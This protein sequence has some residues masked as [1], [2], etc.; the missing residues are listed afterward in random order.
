MCYNIPGKCEI[1]V[2][3]K[4]FGCDNKLGGRNYLGV[5][6]KNFLLFILLGSAVY[7]LSILVVS[8]YDGSGISSAD[9]GRRL[10]EVGYSWEDEFSFPETLYSRLKY[11]PPVSGKSYYVDPEHGSMDNDG[12]R[13][14]PWH[15]LQEV[16]ASGLIQHYSYKDRPYKAGG[17]KVLVNPEAPVKGGDELVLLSGDHGTVRTGKDGF[18][19]EP[20]K[21]LTVRA[22]RGSF[23]VLS[24]LELYSS[25]YL[26]FTDID[27]NF[28]FAPMDNPPPVIASYNH[29]YS[30][31]SGN[32]IISHCRVHPRVST[33]GWS[34]KD[35]KRRTTSA[36][37]LSGSDNVVR[38]C[39]LTNIALGIVITGNRSVVYNNVIRNFTV[40]GMRGNGSEL[41]F[42]RNR[43]QGSLKVDDNHD[44]GFQSFLTAG[45]SSYE[46]VIIKNNTFLQTMDMSSRFLGNFQGIGCFDGPY[47]NWVITGN[48]I[49]TDD[50]HGISLY[51][52]DD[53]L[54]ED[55]LVLPLHLNAENGPP[56]IALV[57][58]KDGR[59]PVNSVVR[60]N[61]ALNFR[62]SPQVKSSANTT[63]TNKRE[64]NRLIKRYL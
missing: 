54:I 18:Y 23:P 25:G 7:F 17:A 36:V 12:S 34:K 48:V 1:K 52:A 47:K 19:L 22:G 30:G 29:S 43:V 3:E 59:E 41:V 32:I 27:F 40:D 51:G 28:G 8:Y 10:T 64:V 26:Y 58:S 5:L 60:N 13:E 14:H 20:G 31:E 39:A 56:W 44:D 37:I 57:K 11:V 33:A 46:N 42:E 49:I 61:R 53:S 4:Y 24:G 45:A 2:D 38:N 55:N 50:W 35:W 63:L 62:L 6:M 15:T 9:T 16:F 21:F